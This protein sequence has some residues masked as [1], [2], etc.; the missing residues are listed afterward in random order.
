[1]KSFLHAVLHSYSLL[2]FSQHRGFALLLLLA[3][4]AQPWA[5]LAGLGAAA[6]A[7]GTARLAGFNQELT[8][9]GAYSFNALLVGLCLSALYQPGWGLLGLIGVGA[10]LALL[11]SVALGG[12]LGGRGLPP[13][14]LPFVAVLWL[15]LPV[16][17]R[18]PQLG[19]SERGIYWLNDVYALG[20]APLVSAARWVG[21]W[22]WPP[23]LGTYLRALSSV[24]L[25]D[26]AA[27][28]LLV[29]LG[30]LW[31]SRIAFTL[32]G[33]AFGG[34]YGLALLTGTLPG[35]SETY[36]LGANYIMTALAVG[37]VFVIPSAGSYALALGSVPL[38]A[39][40]LAGL[41]TLLGRAGLSVFSLPFC[42]GALLVLYALLLRERPRPGLVLTPVQRYSPERNLYAYHTDRIRL[43]HQLY[44]PLT[45]PFLGEWRCSQGYDDAN[46]THQG[47][48]GQALDFVI[49]DADGRTYAGAGLTLTD[50]YAYNKPV[51][52]PADGVVEEVVQHIENNPI[53]EVNLRQNWGNTVVLRHAPGLYTQLSHLRPHSVPLKPGD[54]VRRGDLVGYCGSSGRSPE[55]HLHFQVQATPFVGSRTLAYPLAYFLA[56]A[57]SATPV[58]L[59]KRHLA[60]PNGT[61]HSPNAI[62]APE[63]AFDIAETL[64]EPGQTPLGGGKTP[65]D[66]AQTALDRPQTPF[67][68]TK[69]PPDFTKTSLGGSQTP[70]GGSQTPFGED[71]T[72]LG[73]GKTPFERSKT[74]FD[75]ALTLLGIIEPPLGFP[76]AHGA[77]PATPQLRHFA[78]PAAGDAVSPPTPNRPLSQA[79]RLSPGTVLQVQQTHSPIHPSTHSPIESWEVF[80]DAYN[81]RYL[82][83]QRTG[84]VAYF[85]SDDAVFYC[86]AY[87]GPETAWLYAFYLAAYR[88]PLIQP[89]PAE[90]RDV[91]PLS[92]L[93]NPLLKAAQDL[94]APFHR[95]VQPTFCLRPAPPEGRRQCLRSRATVRAFGREQLL[96][97]AELQI[98]DGRLASLRLTR[99]GAEC[100]LTFSPGGA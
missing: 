11:L 12:W 47:D 2:F 50:Y 17:A 33:L 93:R 67:G 31:H 22:A 73:G 74:P 10:L 91:L 9:L 48:W 82:R 62:L 95:F 32:S 69:T 46:P 90:T 84:A 61:W 39:V 36:N 87:Y 86:I 54:A 6:L 29:A 14:S 49:T 72:P 8:D 99:N 100:T 55:P 21:E 19:L 51:L 1:M 63:T 35:E 7:V 44:L 96:Q 71:K 56:K 13:L 59:P 42:L 26:S 37:G 53:G 98:H 60:S 40:L 88:V 70:F 18:L 23:L 78:V 20:G 97:A 85:E 65:S 64:F 41:S 68:I 43:Q 34:A 30:L 77:R 52:A 57:A 28:G 27:A 4:F 75:H 92:V 24:L 45:L 79:L 38:T 3:T 15:L 83:C 16:A 58:G 5:G 66:L 94:L 80:T 89:T 25:Q 76:S 81:L